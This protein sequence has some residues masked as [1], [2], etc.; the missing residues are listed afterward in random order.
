MV[1]MAVGLY[2]RLLRKAGEQNTADCLDF[3]CT[4]WYSLLLGCK[5]GRIQVSPAIPWLVP[6]MYHRALGN[7]YAV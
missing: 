6:D 7:R 5:Q 1:V 3:R 2:V 4:S